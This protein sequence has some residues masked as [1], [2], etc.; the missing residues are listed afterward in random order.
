MMH[1]TLIISGA[2][3]VVTLGLVLMQPAPR[4]WV[5]DAGPISTLNEFVTRSSQSQLL[6][7][8]TDLQDVTVSEALLTSAQSTHI[9]A[10]LAVAPN[11]AVH[12]VRLGD[13]LATL[14]EHYYDDAAKSPMILEANRRHLGDGG[15]LR[16][17]Q[18]LRI[19]DIEGL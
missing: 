11:V 15:A 4:Q 17:G 1:L 12:T 5:P 19:P 8:P 18:M 9:R 2:F 13:S 14:A 3:M 6:L 16:V 10:R 7:Q